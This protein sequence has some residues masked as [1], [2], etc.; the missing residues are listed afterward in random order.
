MKYRVVLF[1][2]SV[3]INST[4]HGQDVKDSISVQNDIAFASHLVKSEQFEDAIFFINKIEHE[5]RM[6]SYSDSLNYMKGWAFYNLKQLDSSAFFLLQVS[7]N[8]FMQQKSHFFAAYN[9][10]FLGNKI[11]AEEIL[12]HI[13]LRDSQLIELRHLELAGMELLNRDISNYK[14]I[15]RKFSYNRYSLLEAENSLDKLCAKYESFKP[16]SVVLAGIMSAVIPGS[17]KMYSG[18]IGEGVSALL[19]NAIL[20]GITIENY[21]KAGPKN[22]K[23]I[24]FGTLFTIFYTGNIYGSMVSVQVSEKEFNTTYDK[25]VLFDIHIPLRTIFN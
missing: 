12:K 9:N 1:F 23:T 21:R 19:S 11:Q 4:I 15:S 24:F 8:S 13:T 6:I 17:G 3:I 14:E 2:L 18:R 7:D 20:A 16:K 22:F 25:A 10:L 5:K